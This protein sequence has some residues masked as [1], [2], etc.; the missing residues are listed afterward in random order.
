M[1]K[2]TKP[3]WEGPEV[4]IRLLRTGAVALTLTAG[5]VAAVSMTAG[6]TAANA[7]ELRVLVAFP[8]TFILTREIAKPYLEGVTKAS[9][10]KITFKVNGPDAV[11]TFQQFQPTRAG[12]FDLLFTH[13][14]Y[15]AGDTAVGLS[16]DAIAVDPKKRRS[17]GV[18]DYID[19]H[20]QARGLKLVAAPATG[21]RG[22]RFFLR[23]P[24]SAAPGLKGM[25]I[26]GTVSYHPMI[27]TLGGSP[28]VLPGGQV[29]TSLQKGVIDG[30]AWGLTGAYDFK[31]YEVSKYMAAPE[32]GQVGMMIFMN[33]KKWKSLGE[34]DRTLLA[35]QG[36]A[37]EL[38]TIEHFNTLAAKEFKALKGKG[39][40]VTRFKPEDAKRL[41]RLWAEGVWKIAEAK[42]GDDAK[43]LRALARKAGMTY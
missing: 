43:K 41:D 1:G 33:L 17:A 14:A 36:K 15:H 8:E 16:I 20:Y 31:W 42:S 18:I 9:G 5:T 2:T 38:S 35:E 12:V 7:A 22:F 25:K 37:L 4:T 3:D 24:I 29:Y 11:P 30:A 21:T 19:R 39:M 10:G 32:F 13:P 23:K 27:K 28:V 40:S 26:R 6:T 34:A